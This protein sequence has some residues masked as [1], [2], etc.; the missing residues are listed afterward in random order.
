MS[1]M[2]MEIILDHYRNPRNFGHLAQP[3]VKVRDSNPLCGD[4]LEMHLKIDSG[5]RVED[6]RFNG[7]GCA[8]SQAS[9]SMLTEFVLGKK[10]AD[11]TKLSKQ[12]ILQMLGIEV[13]VVRLKC[14]LLPLK[15]LKMAIYSH[16][17]AALPAEDQQLA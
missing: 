5:Q 10:L 6:V 12:D 2:Y 16:L 7:R 3:D 8:I 14:A 13:S 9:A 11:L 4:V 17:G 15:V 1:S